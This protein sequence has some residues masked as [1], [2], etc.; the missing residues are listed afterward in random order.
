M[1]QALGTVSSQDSYRRSQP[2][3]LKGLGHGVQ[4]RPAV[5]EAIPS[6]SKA[7][8]KRAGHPS[9]PVGVSSSKMMV[10]GAACRTG[11]RGKDTAAWSCV[12]TTHGT[13]WTASPAL[14]QDRCFTG[15]VGTGVSQGGG[16]FQA[17]TPPAWTGTCGLC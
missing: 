3:D 11:W 12:A 17:A 1:G 13:S 4:P 10:L 8:Q 14:P 15:A 9:C 2:K 6:V 7:R 16:R 5:E